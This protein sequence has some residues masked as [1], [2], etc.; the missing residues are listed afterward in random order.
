MTDEVKI[1]LTRAGSSIDT[2]ILGIGRLVKAAQLRHGTEG[3]KTA[4]R[5]VA[6]YRTTK[7]VYMKWN[8]EIIVVGID[9][10]SAFYNT[11]SGDSNAKE[12]DDLAKPRKKS[13]VAN[14]G[15]TVSDHPGLANSLSE[16]FPFYRWHLFTYVAKYTTDGDASSYQ[17]I[18]FTHNI[19]RQQ[20]PHIRT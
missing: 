20:D 9:S 8:T 5:V 14:G 10:F 3:W 2:R 1:T 17:A 13:T 18:R 19:E 12:Q 11:A 7:G 6:K 15:V 16:H 4:S